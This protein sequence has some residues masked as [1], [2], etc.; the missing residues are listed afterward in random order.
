MRV[1]SSA[2][3]VVNVNR[4]LVWQLPRGEYSTGVFPT[5]AV[6]PVSCDYTVPIN[7]K[8]IECSDL[9]LTTTPV[10]RPSEVWP[11]LTRVSGE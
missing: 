3:G 7:G 10:G 9:R 11:F 6:N 4:E 1:S 5:T 8:M 2:M